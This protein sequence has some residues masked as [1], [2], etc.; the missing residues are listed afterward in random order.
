MYKR[1][2]QAILIALLMAVETIAVPMSAYGAQ[3]VS[4]NAVVEVEIVETDGDVEEIAEPVS[5]VVPA[6]KATIKYSGK[7]GDLDWS[8]DTNGHLTVTGE[9]EFNKEGAEANYHKPKWLEY[10]ATEIKSAKISVKGI[11]NMSSFFEGCVN[12]LKVDFSDSDT[13]QVAYMPL[14]FYECE[15][16]TEIDFSVVDTGNVRNMANMFAGCSSLSEIDISNF[17][18]D[19][20]KTMQGMFSQC[21]SLEEVE[22]GEKNTDSLIIMS[23]MFQECKKLKE[24]DLSTFDTSKV[25]DMSALFADCWSLEKIDISNFSLDARPSFDSSFTRC[26]NLRELVIPPNMWY[27]ALL[28]E[29][30]EDEFWMDSFGNICERVSTDLQYV[31]KYTKEKVIEISGVELSSISHQIYTGEQI[32]PLLQ[33]TDKGKILKKDID[34]TLLYKNNINPGVA[35]ITINGKGKYK[36]TRTTTF[37]IKVKLAKSK[38]DTI[39]FTYQKGNLEKLNSKNYF[40]LYLDFTPVNF[41][42]K[43]EI[44]LTNN[45]GKKVK[46]VFVECENIEY[47]TKTIKNL[48]QGVYGVRI[49]AIND[50]SYGEWSEKAYVVRQPRSQARSYNGN[51]QIKW[52]KISGATGYDI[53][54]SG[55]R[56][57]TYKKVASVGKK[58]SITTIKKFNRKKL[59][60]KKYYYYIVA[61]KKVGKKTYKSGKGFVNMVVNKAMK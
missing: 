40:A 22:F 54:M 1:K 55:T 7:S 39:D 12:L 34:Y 18:T 41:A 32:L 44:E 60:S 48:S 19:N 46:S 20:V 13:S 58:V 36:G 26:Y 59:K 57:G 50:D 31:T 27:S 43:Y 8:I 53:Y 24:I 14:M 52:E 38:I 37:I 6:E 23:Y 47:V 29:V 10:Y 61:K 2:I 51:V 5:D 28:P 45:K 16:L 25:E 11:T 15:K 49:R 33:L 21:I 35:T 4:E 30:N 17:K 3:S 9:G 56:N 42:K